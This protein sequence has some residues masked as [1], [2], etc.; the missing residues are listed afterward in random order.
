MSTLLVIEDETS[1]QKL[2]KANLVASGYRVLVAGDGE[3]GI[4]LVK[5]ERPGLIFLDLR[6]PDISGWDVLA[7]LKSDLKFAAIPVVVMTA[8]VYGDGEEKA[9]AMGAVDYMVKPFTVDK[10][11]IIVREFIG[12]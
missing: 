9:R 4:K 10:L 1:I 3:E 12:E 6:L 7:W 5:R 11:L 2:L 8:S